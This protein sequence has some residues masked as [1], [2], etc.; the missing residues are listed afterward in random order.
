M[1]QHFIDYITIEKRRSPHTVLA[2]QR[3]LNEFCAFLEVDAA[4]FTPQTVRDTDIRR[5]LISMLD[6]GEKPTSVRRKLSALHT[7]WKFL[8]KTSVVDVDITRAIIAPK[9]EKPLPVFFKPGEMQEAEEAMAY[10]DDYTSLRDNLIIEM[11]YETGMRCAEL[12]GLTDVDIDLSARQIRVFGKRRKERIVPFG[13]HLTEMIRSY[14]DARDA[15]FGLSEYPSFLLA[16]S[17]APISTNRVYRI[18]RARMGEVS[19]QKKH[20]PHVLRHT[21]ATTMLNNGA[22]ITAIK[23]LLG[24]SSLSSTQIYTHTTFEQIRKV[25]NESH[26]RGEK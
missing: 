5:W 13:E 10:A 16:D 26:P 9:K 21:F 3:D 19:T 6:A 1:I 14:M 15:A 2:Y 24:H 17:G 7:F 18:V 11:L 4:N 22:D 23:N 25:Y 8:L 20:S 12:V